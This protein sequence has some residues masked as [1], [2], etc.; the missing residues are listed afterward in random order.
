VTLLL[1]CPCS[2]SGYLVSELFT[3][4]D[5]CLVPNAGARRAVG[6]A[7][8]RHGWGANRG[9]CGPWS[10]R[11]Q[12]EFNVPIYND[13]RSMGFG[14]G[15][16]WTDRLLDAQKDLGAVPN[17]AIDELRRHGDP[18]KLDE[19]LPKGEVHTTPKGY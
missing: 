16:N 2:Q 3:S 17:A 4:S 13:L 19:E 18:W 8:G 15:R 7:W 1:A 12:H 11:L 5:I 14:F 6:V 10:F 9:L